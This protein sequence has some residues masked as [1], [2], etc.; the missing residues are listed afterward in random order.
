MSTLTLIQTSRSPNLEL[1]AEALVVLQR[2]DVLICDPGTHGAYISQITDGCS[3]IELDHFKP[4]FTSVGAQVPFL[5][6]EA[7]YVV[8]L[9]NQDTRV[10]DTLN[11]M[12]G[13]TAQAVF[14]V[15]A[16]IQID[17]RVP[18]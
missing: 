13:N 1:T 7:K 16:T 12:K 9:W 11:W 18:R 4:P 15:D 8:V 14:E 5:D 10:P 3:T 2:A 17:S 6:G